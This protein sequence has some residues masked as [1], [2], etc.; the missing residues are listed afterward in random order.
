MKV[1][2]DFERLIKNLQK[3]VMMEKGEKISVREITKKIA[4]DPLLTDF[5]K[6]L[7]GDEQ[8]VKFKIK[9]D[10]GKI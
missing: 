9:F 2:Q 4:R 10:G 5:E 7:L 3:K 1:D 8:N 6:R